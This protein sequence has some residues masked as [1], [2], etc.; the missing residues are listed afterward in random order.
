M[1]IDICIDIGNNQLGA[2]TVQI[3]AQVVTHVADTL[4]SNRQALKIV[5]T[6]FVGNCGLD[7]VENA[8]R[9]LGRRRITSM[10]RFIIWR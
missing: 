1:A 9:G 4:D 5:A 7:A 2:C 10:I 6:Q 8:T 3:L